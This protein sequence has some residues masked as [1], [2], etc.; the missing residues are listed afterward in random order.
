MKKAMF[1]ILIVSLF[2]FDKSL[3]VNALENNVFKTTTNKDII[4]I[5]EDNLSFS[6]SWQ[7]NKNEYK[8]NFN[9]SL[10]LLNS[11]SYLNKIKKAIDI[12]TKRQYLFF[13]HH[14]SLPAT[15]TIKVRADKS[16]SDGDKLYLYYFNDQT[17]KLEYIDDNLIVKD[18]FVEFKI[19]HCSDYILTGSIVKV[20]MNNPK[21]MSFI[22]ITLIIIG[23][24]L[25]GA[26]LFVN[27]KR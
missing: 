14:G 10:K 21:N 2:Y 8:D 12:N 11:S 5:V 18:G 6:H 24:I 20:A 15:A 16:F 22:I 9:F 7:F 27:N 26:T 1:M 17:N 13:E 25:V 19:K 23:V 3:T 4:Y